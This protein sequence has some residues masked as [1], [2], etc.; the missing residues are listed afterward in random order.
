[1]KANQESEMNNELKRQIEIQEKK[2]KSLEDELDSLKRLKSH[3]KEVA[4]SEEKAD[5]GMIDSQRNQV[6]RSSTRSL[7][8]TPPT[9]GDRRMAGYTKRYRRNISASRYFLIFC[10]SSL[11]V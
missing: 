1:M 3:E 10:S 8:P 11:C 6:N 2:V 5:D 9:S 4:R 7:I